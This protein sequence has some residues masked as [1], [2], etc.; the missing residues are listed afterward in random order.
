MRCEQ[1]KH[2]GAFSIDMDTSIT[3]P[4][5]LCAHMHAL[6]SRP[7]SCSPKFVHVRVCTPLILYA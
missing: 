3:P 2:H 1:S 4:Q 6:D 7:I 5:S